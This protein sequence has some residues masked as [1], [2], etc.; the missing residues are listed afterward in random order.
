MTNNERRQLDDKFFSYAK[1]VLTDG[2]SDDKWRGVIKNTFT[3]FAFTQI[4]DV[5]KDYYVDCDGVLEI[6]KENYISR[7]TFYY[8]RD[9]WLDTAYK[10]ALKYKLFT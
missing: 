5:M 6:V 7:R 3:A 10:W 8:W 2:V 4:Y 1:E 9:E